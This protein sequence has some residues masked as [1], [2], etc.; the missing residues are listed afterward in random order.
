MIIIK[1]WKNIEKEVIMKLIEIKNIFESGDYANEDITWEQDGQ[2]FEGNFVEAGDIYQVRLKHIT[3]NG[4]QFRQFQY[5]TIYNIQFSI[6]HNGKKSINTTDKKIP[7]RIFGAVQNAA[8]SKL[9]ENN[10]VPDIISLSI[11][12]KPDDNTPEEVNQRLR[13]YTRIANNMGP[14]HGY[15]DIH[16]DIPGRF[17]KNVIMAN[18][19]LLDTDLNF[20]KHVLMNKQDE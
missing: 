9:S 17:S 20:I 10:I 15:N 11:S 4:P 18:Y 3:L 1:P 13:I 19:K 16:A 14:K 5:K 7:L 2:S 8:L 12:T 6:F